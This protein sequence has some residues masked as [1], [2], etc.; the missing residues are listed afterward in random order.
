MMKLILSLALLCMLCNTAGAL[1]CEDSQKNTTHSCAPNE[2]CA[3]AVSQGSPGNQQSKSCV[4]S[5]ICNSVNQVFSFNFGFYNLTASVKCCKTNSCNSDD[6]TYPDKQE[7]NDLKCFICDNCTKTVQC[8]GDQDHCLSG[9]VAT[10]NTAEK[11]FGCASENLCEASSKL[12]FLSDYLNFTSG[13]NCCVSSLC[14]SASTVK[15]SVAPFLLG[16]IMLA[17]C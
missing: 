2:Y 7:K 8:V 15:L 1:T 6:V 16:L 14:N 3:A 10:N 17:A 12:N 13:P 11:V 5:S 4:A 9:S